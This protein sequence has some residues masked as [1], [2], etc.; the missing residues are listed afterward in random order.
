[1][2]EN[3][4][5]PNRRFGR[6]GLISR[7]LLRAGSCVP[8]FLPSFLPSFRPSFLRPSLHRLYIRVYSC[9]FYRFHVPY[10]RIITPPSIVLPSSC[11]RPA[12]VL[13]SSFPYTVS[14]N[15]C[16]FAIRAILLSRQ[17][18]HRFSLFHL[19]IP[20][21]FRSVMAALYSVSF[22]SALIHNR[23][24]RAHARAHMHTNARS[25]TRAFKPKRCVFCARVSVC[26][27]VPASVYVYVAV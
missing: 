14:L 20:N 17:R 5:T 9:R 7:Q 11:H 22:S 18:R 4:L 23:T 19:F 12:I 27:I 2:S 25:H 1:M 21:F 24:P 15:T 26:V 8:S 10:P 13:P 3:G 16:L 6:G